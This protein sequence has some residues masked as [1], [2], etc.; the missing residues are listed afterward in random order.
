M[1]AFHIKRAAS[2]QSTKASSSLAGVFQQARNGPTSRSVSGLLWK[3]HQHTAGAALASTMTTTAQPVDLHSH[4]RP[5]LAAAA[6]VAL[7]A[8]T[9]ATTA[10]CE[11]EATPPHKKIPLEHFGLTPADVGKENFEEV[12]ASHN[13]DEMPIYSSDDVA[14]NNG[15][16]GKPIWMSYG[17]VVCKFADVEWC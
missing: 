1:F 15:E 10:Q 14:K 8:V 5:L 6:L 16:D 9:T 11:E 2:L 4:T 13:V 3:R 12:Q 17:G 7:A